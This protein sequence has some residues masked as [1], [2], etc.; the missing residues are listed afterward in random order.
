MCADY[1][2]VNGNSKLERLQGDVEEVKVIMLENRN[3]AE[4]RGEKLSDLNDRAEVLREKAKGF[5][6]TTRKLVPNNRCENK[7]VVFIAIGVVAG[8]VILGLVIFFARVG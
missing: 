2:Q 5:E 6:K 8:L 4:D 7:K 3:K 1:L